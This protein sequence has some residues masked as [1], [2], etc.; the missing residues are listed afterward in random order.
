MNRKAQ[1]LA[2]AQLCGLGIYLIPRY[3]E[4]LNAIH[5]A[6]LKLLPN[7]VPQGYYHPLWYDYEKN[8][9]VATGGTPTSWNDHDYQ[10]ATAS[11]KTEALLKAFGLWEKTEELKK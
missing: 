4:D 3:T 1:N 7:T 2:I 8:L 5:E 9:R 11:Q 6:I 10:M